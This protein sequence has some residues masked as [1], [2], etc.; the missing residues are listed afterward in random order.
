MTSNV[1]NIADFRRETNTAEA[2]NLTA[3]ELAAMPY[4]AVLDWAGSSFDKLVAA[5]R[6]RDYRP[7]WVLHQMEEHGRQLTGPGRKT[8]SCVASSTLPV[9]I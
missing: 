6:A 1:V 9:L 3:E 7:E 4:P 2:P 8:P 5:A